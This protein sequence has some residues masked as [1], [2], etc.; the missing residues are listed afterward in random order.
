MSERSLKEVAERLQIAE[1][2]LRRWCQSLEQG[3]YLF[4]KKDNKRR[5]LSEN[6]VSALQQL[7]AL[8]QIMSIEKAWF[9]RATHCSLVQ[10]TK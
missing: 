9:A 7:K 5:L 4:A 6:D 8:N 2:T 3:G 10:A 1:S